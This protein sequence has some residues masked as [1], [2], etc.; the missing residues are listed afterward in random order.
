MTD[1]YLP[2]YYGK[3]VRLDINYSK[4]AMLGEELLTNYL[5]TEDGVQ[6]QQK[7]SAGETSCSA[8]ITINECTN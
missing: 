6:Y 8:K 4:E 5:V 1:A 2:D 3:K 7:N